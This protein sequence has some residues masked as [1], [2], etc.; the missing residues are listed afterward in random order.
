MPPSDAAP[1]RRSPC[2]IAGTL[3]I[4]GDTWSLVILR[5]CINGKARFS[6]FLD[7]PERITPS[8]LT[9][10][11]ARME[12]A[13]LLARRRYQD[14]PPRYDYILT[15]MGRG[16]LPVLQEICRWANRFLPGTWIPPA[17]FM[18]LRV[19]ELRPD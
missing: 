3:D 1:G 10:R 5:D 17:Q 13:G 2:P 18:A 7:S 6:E 19:A 4:L 14:R 11:L 16:L 15:P 9:D 8:V 12:R